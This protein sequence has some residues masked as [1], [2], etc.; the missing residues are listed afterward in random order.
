MAQPA[1]FGL[2]MVIQ[3]LGCSIL[4][5]EA[6]FPIHTALKGNIMLMQGFEGTYSQ[7]DTSR[8]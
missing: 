2:K 6:V 3:E 1:R 5:R 7:L 8:I 4:F